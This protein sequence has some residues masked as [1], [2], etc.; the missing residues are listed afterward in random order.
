M[1]SFKFIAISIFYIIS[2]SIYI[3]RLAQGESDTHDADSIPFP[4][5][6]FICCQHLYSMHIGPGRETQGGEG[7]NND[8]KPFCLCIHDGMNIYP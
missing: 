1:P 2:L 8:A 7:V 4:N 3:Y 5:P 6:K